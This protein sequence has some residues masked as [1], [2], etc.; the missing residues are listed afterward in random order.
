MDHYFPRII[1]SY[2]EAKNRL[3]Y[4]SYIEMSIRLF[5]TKQNQYFYSLKSKNLL[6]PADIA[7]V[8]PLK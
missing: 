3:S 5:R 7:W 2:K 8:H 4:L 1:E 6:Q